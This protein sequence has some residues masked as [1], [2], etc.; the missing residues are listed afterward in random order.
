MRDGSCQDVMNDE[1]R[2][3]DEISSLAKCKDQACHLRRRYCHRTTGVELTSSPQTDHA[4]TTA[5]TD[6]QMRFCLAQ[7]FQLVCLELVGL[8]FDAVV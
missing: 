3:I 4:E 7:C 8:L 5:Y 2:S 1:P 6:G